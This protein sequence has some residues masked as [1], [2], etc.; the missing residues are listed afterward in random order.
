[1]SVVTIPA[2]ILIE[3]VELVVHVDRC[4]QVEVLKCDLAVDCIVAQV[5]IAYRIV[6]KLKIIIFEN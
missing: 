4:F 5:I 1:M 3:I 2:M 6:I